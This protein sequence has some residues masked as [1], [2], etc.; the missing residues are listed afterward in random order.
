MPLPT[1]H[2]GGKPRVLGC[3]PRTIGVGQATFAP[4]YESQFKLLPRDQWRPMTSDEEIRAFVD[5]LIKNIGEADQDRIGACG[6][7]AT[8]RG[9]GASRATR[10]QPIACL[11]A[12]QLYHF[13][14][15]GY[16]DGSQ[17]SDNLRYAMEMGIPR[18]STRS[19]E[20]DY[21][22]DWTD[23][24]VRDALDNRITGAVDCPSFEHLVSAIHGPCDAVIHGIQCGTDYEVDDSGLWIRPQ[25]NPGHNDGHAQCSPA[26]GLCCRDGEFGLLVLGSWSLQFGY[27]GCYV[28][29]ECYFT[30][31]PFNDGWGVYA[32]TFTG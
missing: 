11:S 18:F 29:P 27:K 19:R 31:T 9:E 15:G 8:V 28:V 24:E 12:G 1:I 7:F 25:R 10:G 21:A 17:L 6:A 23:E 16:D 22:S 3:L 4:H 13:S 5:R 2:R 14:G 30:N 26:G 32:T 20:L